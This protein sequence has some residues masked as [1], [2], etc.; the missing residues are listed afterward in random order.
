MAAP[1]TN[2][3]A[4]FDEKYD[5]PHS[6]TDDLKTEEDGD[7]VVH[8]L[9][10]PFPPLKGLPHEENPLTVRAVIVGIILG[11]LVNASNVYLGEYPACWARWSAAAVG[12]APSVPRQIH[13]VLRE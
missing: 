13:L 5:L 1:A 10:T 7:D 8:D 2:A 3:A 9:F 4:P 12:H 11:S 6:Q